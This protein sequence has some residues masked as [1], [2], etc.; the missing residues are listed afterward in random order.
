MAKK[1]Q[2][3]KVQL[4]YKGKQY[5]IVGETAEHYFLSK[6]KTGTKKFTIKK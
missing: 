6:S 4:T 5:Y 2:E 3:E 1:K